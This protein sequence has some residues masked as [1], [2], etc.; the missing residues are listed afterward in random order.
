MPD[1]RELCAG[2]VAEARGSEEIE[3]YAESSRHVQVRVRRGEVESLTSAE[4]RGL[5]VRAVVGGRVG[6]AYGADPT[7][8]E[9]AAL[10]RAARESAAFAE[11]DEANVLPEL[12]PAVPLAGVFRQ[13]PETGPA[14]PKGSPARGVD[15]APPAPQPDA[16]KG[17]VAR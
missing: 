14:E 8:E 7:P 13:A 15:A 4:T 12:V 6:Y 9:V 2:A 3:A 16:R 1:L 17:E 5:G 11:A 10:V